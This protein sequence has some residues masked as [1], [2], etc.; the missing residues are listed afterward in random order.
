MSITVD[1][2]NEPFP[3]Y[4]SHSILNGLPKRFNNFPY[5]KS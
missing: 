3:I 2:K 4:F 5:M 1:A